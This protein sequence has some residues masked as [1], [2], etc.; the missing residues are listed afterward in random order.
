M[1]RQ[2]PICP[3]LLLL[4]QEAN[5]AYFV[6]KVMVPKVRVEL[7][8]PCGQWFLSSLPTVLDRPYTTTDIRILA[9]LRIWIGRPRASVTPQHPL[10]KR[11]KLRG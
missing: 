5:T 11:L 8:R 4:I 9:T 1:G 6:S 10:G 3:D 2:N 7:T